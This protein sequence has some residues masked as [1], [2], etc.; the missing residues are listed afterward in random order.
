[1]STGDSAL[2]LAIWSTS[3]CPLYN[4]LFLL[5]DSIHCLHA[6]LSN[7]LARTNG[8]V[9]SN[10]LILPPKVRSLVRWSSMFTWPWWARVHPNKFASQGKKTNQK[11]VLP[12]RCDGNLILSLQR[13]RSV[14]ATANPNNFA[15]QGDSATVTAGLSEWLQVGV[16]A[17]IC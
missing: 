10:G 6:F 17:T 4:V 14:L 13:W 8:S 16:G 2:A 3:P 11:H 9:K 7:K 15:H 5:I 12:T 1:M